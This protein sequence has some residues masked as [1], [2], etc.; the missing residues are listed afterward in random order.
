MSTK[1][2]KRG[3][4]ITAFFLFTIILVGLFWLATNPTQ[5]VTLTLAY[6]AGLSMIFLPCTL[7][8]VFIIIPLSTG[9][10][11]RKGLSMSLLFGL[12]LAVTL[13][14]YGIAVAWL[15]DYFGLDEITRGMFVVAG[16]AAY[17]FGLTELDLISFEI[18]EIG[19]LPQFIQE[20]GNY[21]KSFIM[22]VFLGNA[23][24]GCPNPAFYV[25]LAF[26]ATTGNLFYG[27]GLGLVHG[28][29]RATPLI[30]LS[31]LA[32]LGINASSWISAKREAVDKI[33]GWFL[34]IV[35]VFIFSIGFFG[36]YWWETSFIHQ[37]W[38]E[39]IKSISP[40][41]AE[42]TSAAEFFEIS[43][44]PQIIEK[45]WPSA[46]WWTMGV[47]TIIPAVWLKLRGDL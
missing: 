24:V 33:M 8:L 38:N 2:F 19:G 34:I 26:I 27:G 7:P 18:P 45:Y 10:G 31:I 41:L 23:G 25:L 20:K 9:E 35:G 40:Q 46:P 13:T 36:M 37:Y 32:I 3:L 43:L 15:G 16:I 28:I 21:L 4:G 12:G 1:K 30:F 42:T 44:E 5:T 14:L 17:I 6:A 22:G 39:F 47:F 29:G 11:Y